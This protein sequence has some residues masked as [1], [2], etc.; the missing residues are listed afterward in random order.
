MPL[1]R[2][3]PP[4]SAL[5]CPPRALKAHTLLR[6]LG[7]LLPGLLAGVF[8]V[9]APA[10]AEARPF[11]GWDHEATEARRQAQS[12]YGGAVLAPGTLAVGAQLGFPYVSL[13]LG[14]GIAERLDGRLGMRSLWGAMGQLSVEGRYQIRREGLPVS[15]RLAV[16][17]AF[18]PPG[19]DAILISGTRDLALHPG[20]VISAQVGRGTHFYFDAGLQLVVDLDPPGRPLAGARPPAEAYLNLPLHVGAEVPLAPN[21][22]F[23]ARLGLDLRTGVRDTAEPLMMPFLAL[24]LVLLG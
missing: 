4:M 6:I 18:Y 16:E 7:P 17:Y 3:L 21:L 2:C 12:L 13:D 9:P 14:A 5:R 20:V 15:L 24:G 23:S 19:R 22:R 1:A 8:L 11:L 10:F